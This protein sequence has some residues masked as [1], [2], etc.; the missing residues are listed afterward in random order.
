MKNLTT[1]SLI[2]GILVII[3][4]VFLWLALDMLFSGFNIS[5]NSLI[6]IGVA[7]LVFGILVTLFGFLNVSR[8]W[9]CL[10]FAVSG[11]GIFIFFAF[12]WIYLLGLVLFFLGLVFSWDRVKSEKESRIKVSFRRSATRG[13]GL[14]LTTAIIIISLAY[15]FN[16][17]L[18]KPEK[19]VKV[20]DW[21][22]STVIVPASKMLPISSKELAEQ[23]ENLS[24]QFGIEIKGD[25]EL[26]ELF[27][28]IVNTK[29]NEY[30]GPYRKYISI[31]LAFGLFFALRAVMIPF[32][33]LVLLL[34]GVTIKILEVLK[35][36]QIKKEQKELD[37]V[38]F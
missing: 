10:V 14:I 27:E 23:S 30:L 18:L 4:T 7:L 12:N 37:V 16:S 26:P 1:K 33:L 20:P 31:G 29:M 22:V 35:V 25:E 15:Y 21:M 13:I 6:F 36:V 28:R 34:A 3:S 2:L 11:L 38:S 24:K 17:P 19:E 8:L 32:G 5:F 9:A